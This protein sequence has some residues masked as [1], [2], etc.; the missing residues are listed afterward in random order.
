MKIVACSKCLRLMTC[1]NLP[2]HEIKCDGVLR[3]KKKPRFNK[4]QLKGLTLEQ[5]HG[6]EKA[7]QIKARLS[8]TSTVAQKNPEIKAKHALA[9]SEGMK[10][11][12]EAGWKPRCGRAKKIEY[13]SPIAGTISVDGSWELKTA[14]HLDSLGVKWYRNTKRFS[15]INLTGGRSTYCPDFYV[16]DWG[17]YIEV[18]GYET[19]L[20]RCKWR[21]FPEPIEVWKREKIESMEA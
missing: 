1:V 6:E 10:K 14:K 16:E 8:Y 15:Y 2:R 20:D 21:Q 13:N 18:K 11:K 19:E 7:A 3:S 5:L 9:V 12:Y 17:K 4:D